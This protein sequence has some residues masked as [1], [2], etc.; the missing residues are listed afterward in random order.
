MGEEEETQYSDIS[1]SA[2]MS[3][4]YIKRTVFI[5]NLSCPADKN[6]TIKFQIIMHKILT[7]N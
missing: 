7:A 2:I 5:K 6:Y 4:L 1:G 3:S